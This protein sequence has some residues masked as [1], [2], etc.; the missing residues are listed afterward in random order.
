MV[1]P[2]QEYHEDK[3]KGEKDIADRYSFNIQSHRLTHSSL[4]YRTGFIW[5]KTIQKPVWH[6]D[7][8]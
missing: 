1:V 5:Q 6:G 3:N 8:N 7:Y 2:L 4:V